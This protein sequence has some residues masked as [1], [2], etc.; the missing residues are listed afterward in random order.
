MKAMLTRLDRQ[1]QQRFPNGYYNLIQKTRIRFRF[2][3]ERKLSRGISL[4]TS[5]HPSILFFTTQKCA[6]RY[7]N[8]ILTRLAREEGM[9]PID[10]DAYVTMDRPPK[11]FNPFSPQGTLASAFQT[12][13]YYYG[14]IGSWRDIPHMKDYAVALQLRDP[15]DVLTSLYYST[16]FSHALINRKMI[17]RREIARQMSVD[18]YVL[19]NADQFLRIYQG[20]SEKLIGSPGVLFLKYEL[21]VADFS[22][23][24][25][26]LSSY[27]GFSHHRETLQQIVNEADFQVSREDQFA[28]RRQVTPGD[29]LRKLEGGTVQT[30]NRLFG[31]LL[32]ELGYEI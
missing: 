30:L 8:D 7:V 23:W 9:Q 26:Q 10:F 14:P 21:M 24:L 28:Q 31:P 27:L 3:A 15:R 11:P 5:S 2:Q 32:K 22:T 17:R 12:L 1:L 19:D 6:S 25:D 29:H 20:Y 16:A 13:G 4:S 18:E